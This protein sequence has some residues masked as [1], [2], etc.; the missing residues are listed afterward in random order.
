M[1]Q[2]AFE[3]LLRCAAPFNGPEHLKAWL[4][5]VVINQC[6]NLHR[7][8]RQRDVPLSEELAN[9]IAAPPPAPDLMGEVKQL[10]EN[11]RN[12]VYLHYIEGYTAAEI[13]RLLGAPTATVLT[14]LRRGRKALQKQMIGGF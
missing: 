8:A 2:E 7:A 4:I 11:Y 6:H 10:P 13:G 1:V 5:R 14:W 12:A 3:K 9:T